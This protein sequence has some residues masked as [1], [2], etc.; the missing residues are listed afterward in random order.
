MREDV[1]TDTWGMPEEMAEM[2]EMAEIT[3][4]M[5]RE[6]IEAG[7]SAKQAAPLLR[8]SGYL[9][10]IDLWMRHEVKKAG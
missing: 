5:C 4:R 1:I 8:F 9:Q 7:A 2:A 6:L 10:G 3:E